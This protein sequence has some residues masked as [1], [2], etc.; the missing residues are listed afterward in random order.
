MIYFITGNKNKYIEAKKIIKDIEMK[1]IPYPEIQADK[2]EDVA[3]FGEEYLKKQVNE[4]FFI[5]DSGIFIDALKNFP[6]V[7]S[8]YIFKTIGNEGILKLMEGIESRKARFES[9][10]AFY[11]GSLHIFKGVCK[12]KISYNARGKGFGYDPIFIP[13]GSEKTFGEMSITEKN[14]YSHRGKAI[15]ALSSLLAPL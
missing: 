14:K 5:E 8:A 12:G 9:V 7:Y 2:L 13:D 3:E 6:G 10:I 11:D 15:R 4:K 1:H